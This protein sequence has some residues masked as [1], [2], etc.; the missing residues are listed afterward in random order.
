MV[1]SGL[2]A[3]IV[4]LGGGPA[5]LSAAY[6]LAR[7]GRTPLVLESDEIVGGLARTVSFKNFLFDIGGHRFFTKSAEVQQ[8]WE[9]ILG[10]QMMTRSR[11]SRIRYRNRFFHYPLKPFDALIGLGPLEAMLIVGS[12]LQW[13]FFPYRDVRNFEQWVTNRFGKRLFEIF[14][15]TYTEKVWGIPCS[16]IS[17]DWAAQRIRNLSMISLLKATL[18]PKRKGPRDKIIKTLIDQFRYPEH[19]PGQMWETCA[20][21]IRQAGSRVEMGVE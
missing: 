14:F 10:S 9:E 17:A 6:E 4:I 21:K 20:D 19:G 15:R 3:R 13:H 11:L 16:E 18:L 7:E 2:S 5:G 1:D 8:L 12:Y